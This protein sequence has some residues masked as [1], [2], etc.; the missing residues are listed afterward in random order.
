MKNAL[1]AVSVLQEG[2]GLSSGEAMKHVAVIHNPG[3]ELGY[4][5]MLLVSPAP[6]GEERMRNLAAE[7]PRRSEKALW[8]PGVGTAAPEFQTLADKGPDAFV[9]EMPINLAPPTDD[10]PYLNYFAKGA[11][12]TMSVLQPYA[13]LAM[14]MGIA[15]LAMFVN[16]KRSAR[17]CGVPNSTSL[18]ALYGI[19]FMLFELG[20]M[21]KLTLAAG[22]PTR[23][24]TVLLFALLLFC[25]L[26]SLVSS[27]FANRLRVRPGLFAIAVALVGA[28]TAQLVERYYRLEGVSSPVL[29]IAC[30]LAITAPIGFCLGTPFPDLLR[31][32]SQADEHRLAWLWAVNGIGSVLG[33][34]LTMILLPTLGG[35]AVLLVGSALYVMA[36]AID[37]RSEAVA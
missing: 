18:A 20:L 22:G 28:A 31:R 19:G 33:G 15:L 10:K 32:A 11:E 21:A 2:S 26:G 36:W 1:A 3:R 34:A 24:F 17:A 30:V 4:K 16:D 14:A 29:R 6:L 27:R 5:Y 23:V 13:G 25:G 9:R 7:V 8:L 37:R 12:E 35:H